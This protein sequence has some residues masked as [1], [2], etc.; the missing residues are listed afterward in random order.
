MTT[1]SLPIWLRL[2]LSIGGALVV[3]LS[4]M[5]FW[6]NTQNRASAL[7]QASDFATSMYQMTLAGLTGMMITGTV[8]QREVFL[9]QITALEGVRELSVVR[10]DAVVKQFGKGKASER[11][12]DSVSA[13][14]VRTGQATER[15]EQDERGE[16][17]F[18]VKPIVASSNTLGKNCISCHQVAEGTVLGTVS[19][20]ISLDKVN[21]SIVQQRINTVLGSLAV[22]L[23]LIVLTFFFIRHFVTQ[24]IASM[25]QG[26]RDIA[27][28][29]GDLAHRLPVR[30]MDEI[31]HASW[32]FNQMMDKFADLV[33]HIGETVGQVRQSVGGLVS[34]ATEVSR[35][36]EL[37]RLKSCEATDAVDAVARGVASIAG[38]AEG[39]REQSHINL[40]DAE[41]GQQK[42][43]S[44]MSS[45]DAV[46]NSVDG[47]VGS[48][49]AFVDSTTSISDMTRQVKDIAEQ[50]NLLALNAAIE[51]ARAGDQGRGFAVVADEV[52]KLAEK[53]RTS[54]NA[55]DSVTQR[56]SAQSEE[57]MLAIE[58]GL[59][60]LEKSSDDVTLVADVLRRTACGVAHVNEGVDEI[61]MATSA[62]QA[63]SR[64]ASEN[65]G[66]I[67]QLATQNTES[68]S[69]A[70][71][72]AKHLESLAQGL[73]NAVARF[74]LSEKVLSR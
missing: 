71:V 12:P 18:V 50:T 25:A 17:L 16:Y 63:E 59:G 41:S 23:F 38:S 1:K 26:L 60:H 2:T 52:R 24:P 19:M 5:T 69:C 20:K 9:D 31:G 67:A 3:A 42:L 46:R 37:Q 65:I 73:G 28:G 61:G 49:R 51:A 14:V 56:I 13:N 53:S 72:A 7:A 62:Q 70:L 36:S 43:A 45:M 35:I 40:A 22:L 6:Q 32:A 54:A 64:T 55:I 33:R 27:S 11:Q 44:L 15:V 29:E 4:V 68:V 10:S 48:V 34:V 58:A 57:V 30:K 66:E 8:G 74:K 21:A 47:M 39:V